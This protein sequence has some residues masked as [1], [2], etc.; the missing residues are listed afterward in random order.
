MLVVEE[1][2]CN[3]S[4]P[5]V[6]LYID[7]LSALVGHSWESLDVGTGTVEVAAAVILLVGTKA[8][9]TAGLS[10]PSGFAVWIVVP[11]FP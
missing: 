8:A 2:C 11:C 4:A 1:H 5:V 6:V 10:I 9:E 7:Y 3:S